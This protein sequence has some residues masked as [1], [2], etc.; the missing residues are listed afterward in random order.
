MRRR[1]AE[2]A[3][4]PLWAGLSY[5]FVPRLGGPGRRFSL[6]PDRLTWEAGPTSGVLPLAQVRRVTLRL[7]PAKLGHES[8]EMEIR[9][10]GG[11]RVRLASVS[12][13]SF[14]AVR[15]Q[16]AD[17]AAVVR[18]L[19][20]ALAARGPAEVDC[21]GGYGAPRWWAM[22]G[23]GGIA[24]LALLAVLGAALREGDFAFA[25]VFAALLAALTFPAGRMVWRNRPV[26]FEPQSV[27]AHLLPA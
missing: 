22:A 10:A 23:L 12:R 11:E 4:P 21:R 18:A 17:Y 1:V 25:L 16:G 6:E 9:G 2:A 26:T 24:L 19:L 14:T 3:D 20:A 15:D 27:P 5:A 8:Y 7:L 13:Q